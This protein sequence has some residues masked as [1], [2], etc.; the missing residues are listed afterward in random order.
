[1]RSRRNESARVTTDELAAERAR[2]A[3]EYQRRRSDVDDGI[4]APWN[5]S[6][7]LERATRVRVAAS[8]LKDAGVFP[9]AETRVLEV[10]CGHRGWFPDL[11]A[12]GVREPNLLGIDL[13]ESRVGLA[14]AAFPAADLRVGDASSMPYPDASVELV[15]CSTVFTSILSGAMRT[16]VAR[17]IER[18]LRPGGALLWYDFAFDNPRNKSVR[19]V[20]RAELLSL[21]PA[22]RGE[23]QRVTL[24][25]PLARL[26]APRSFVAATALEAIPLLRTHLL[27]VLVKV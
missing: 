15:V 24:A 5:P 10:G 16:A 17:E 6:A 11:L 18:V 1:M 20:K 21:F 22:L 14:H 7:A 25:P 23:V 19:A 9:S 12:F 4:Y 2:I 3:A 13:D 26:I 27:A 8:M